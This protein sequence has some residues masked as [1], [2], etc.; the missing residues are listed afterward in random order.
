MVLALR[1]EDLREVPEMPEVV[2]LTDVGRAEPVA[3][4]SAG[5]LM[6]GEQPHDVPALVPGGAARRTVSAF[7][8]AH[9][10]RSSNVH[11]LTS[12]ALW[13]AFPSSLAG[14]YPCDYYEVSV[15]P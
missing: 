4:A 7:C 15:E 10:F 9:T 5:V 11:H 8:I 12:F 14:R 2:V 13:T 1:G 3:M 6:V